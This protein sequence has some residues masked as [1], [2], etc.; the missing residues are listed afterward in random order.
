[1]KTIDGLKSYIVAIA[2]IFLSAA[3]YLD[4]DMTLAEAVTL[5]L[6]GAGVGALRHGVSKT[7]RKKR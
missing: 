4:G 2:A 1:M 3:F 6:G 7:E 5:G